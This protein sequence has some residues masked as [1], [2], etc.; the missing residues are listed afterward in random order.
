[1]PRV[2]EKKS[3]RKPYEPPMLTI[4]GTVHDVTKSNGRV[5]NPDGGKVMFQTQTSFA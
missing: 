4:Y 2:G 5:G 1:M 3:G